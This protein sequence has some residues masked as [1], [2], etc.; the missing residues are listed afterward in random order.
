MSMWQVLGIDAT[1][2]LSAIRKA[3]A[4][5]LRHTRPDDDA[6][7]YQALRHAYDQAQ[8]YARR[9]TRADGPG[10][11][12][13]ADGTP[14]MPAPEP[15]ASPPGPQ[16]VQCNTDAD[17][18]A[19]PRREH[20]PEPE[21]ARKQE[22]E[23]APEASFIPPRDLAHQ[24]LDHLQRA[25]PDALLA[26]WPQLLRELDRLPLNQRPEACNWFAQL[27]IDVPQLPADFVR[28][29]SGYFAWETD[30]RTGQWLGQARATALRAQLEQL[31]SR[32]RPDPAFQQYYAQISVY[33]QLVQRI[34]R[35]RIHLLAMLAPSRLA[36]LWHELSPQQRYALGVPKP[37]L[38]SLA[39]QAMDNGC[40]F[41]T[42]LVIVLASV[43]MSW[44]G[45]AHE[46][47]WVRLMA[48]L[49]LGYGGF[50]VVS[51]IH[52]WV[53]QIKH[54]QHM[55][56]WNGQISPSRMRAMVWTAVALMAGAMA[57]VGAWEAR[58]WPALFD[59][60]HRT[61]VLFV[62]VMLVLAAYWLAL[63]PGT[64]AGKAFPTL[65]LWCVLCMQAVPW[66]DDMP[67]TAALAGATWLLVC[68]I[69]HTFH[70]ERLEQAWHGF[71]QSVVLRKQQR[72]SSSLQEIAMLSLAGLR[73]TIALPYRLLVLAS[74]QS[75]HF[76]V[77]VLCLALSAIGP[78]QRAWQIPMTA[79]AMALASLFS[80]LCLDSAAT[81]LLPEQPRPAWRGWLGLAL[82]CLWLLWVG[83]FW[84]HADATG[85]S[86]GWGTPDNAMDILVRGFTVYLA[87]L[88]LLLFVQGYFRP[89][90]SA[91]P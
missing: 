4:A 52:R 41:R 74:E 17:A 76:V 88:P 27:V 83:L 48:V 15:P 91:G 1:T 12:V 87:P 85:A 7:A 20:E 13:A 63:L 77:A 36:R 61:L 65:L 56:L 6:Q 35:W 29:L 42:A 80:R 43:L 82:L 54:A 67:W 53:L 23:P 51:H 47:W 9:A 55:T 10:P 79:C 90:R 40:T 81:A 78:E 22:P 39:D 71:R 75:A 32:F 28:A 68:A 62:A 70:G 18:D 60:V 30:F 11:G 16:G 45:Y 69:A 46:P 37:P 66:F 2:D 8:Q 38:H 26:S 44:G 57:I 49:V 58:M 31:D 72:R 19:P 25:G 73:R 84:R 14:P 33:G 86:I 89:S 5:R 50:V 64:P 24:A 21:P 34:A 59:S 3:Y